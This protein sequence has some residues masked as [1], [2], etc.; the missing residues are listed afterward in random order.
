MN[1]PASLLAALLP[2]SL[3]ACNGQEP[4]TEPAPP[5]EQVT[6]T[7][8]Q[9]HTAMQIGDTINIGGM[10][11]TIDLTL[12]DIQVGGSCRY[13]E[14]ESGGQPKPGQT[15]LQLWGELE[16]IQLNHNTWAMQDDPEIV[17]SEGFTQSLD[18]DYK[19]LDA[20]DGYESWTE[21]VD[22]GE[23][24]RVYGVFHMP[25]DAKE[26]KFHNHRLKLADV[27]RQT[28]SAPAFTVPESSQPVAPV[29]TSATSYVTE[30]LEGT[31]GPA[32]WSDGTTRYS[33]ECF[34][35]LGGPAYLESE[36]QSG[37]QGGAAV[38]GYGHAPNGARNPSSG[39]VQTYHGCQD[40]YIDDPELCSAAESVVRSVDPDGSVYG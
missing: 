11:D 2:L 14:S 32:K 12:T 19:C 24:I 3:T 17:D 22:A 28:S 18:L 34:Q 30:C 13:G 10:S 25:E 39:E 38:T 29:A 4:N 9:H 1:R 16:S 21:T 36:S 7:T 15:L 26:I 37:V 6:M 33:E 40:G 5:T 20:D 27:G 31:P 23:K 8:T 35:K